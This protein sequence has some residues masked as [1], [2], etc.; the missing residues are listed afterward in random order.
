[1]KKG[2]AVPA[3]FESTKSASVMGVVKY[4]SP[5]V[6]AASGLVDVRIRY[7]NAKGDIR[8]GLKGTV[9]ASRSGAGG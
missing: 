5:V 9:R 8:P 7:P 2:D 4:V 3:V 6:D 1:L